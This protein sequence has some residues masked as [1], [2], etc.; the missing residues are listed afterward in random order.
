M[1][2]CGASV[3]VDIDR[4]VAKKLRERNQHGVC[5]G[6]PVRRERQGRRPADVLAPP[7]LGH[8][9]IHV[10]LREYLLCLLAFLLVVL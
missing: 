8:V 5:D 7:H 3:P 9:Q 10:S 4:G 1:R 6:T 2:F